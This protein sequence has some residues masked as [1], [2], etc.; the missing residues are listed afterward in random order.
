MGNPL[1]VVMDRIILVISKGDIFP[2]DHKHFF[3]QIVAPISRTSSTVKKNVNA[4]IVI[5]MYL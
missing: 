3:V 5:Y 4:R 1:T 2:I